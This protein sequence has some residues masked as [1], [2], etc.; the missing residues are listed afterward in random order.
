M[1]LRDAYLQL[2]AQD[3]PPPDPAAIRAQEERDE[4]MRRACV[5]VIARADAGQEVDRAYVQ[6]ARDFVATTPALNRPLGAGLARM[7][8]A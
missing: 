7:S 8:A 3:D 6:W 1:S 4:L 5:S 2:L